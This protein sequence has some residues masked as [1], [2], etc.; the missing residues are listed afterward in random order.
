MNL[1]HLFNYTV[2]MRDT[3]ATGIVFHPRY[4]EIL[5]S[6]RESLASQIGLDQ[7]N[8]LKKYGC[9]LVA[10]A[11]DVKFYQPCYLGE[12]IH[13]KTKFDRSHIAKIYL[14]QEIEKDNLEKDQV[15]NANLIFAFI[16][17]ASMQPKP[18]PSELL[19]QLNQHLA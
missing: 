1:M 9:V 7:N 12:K 16:D 10:H 11:I 2:S 15:L 6:A 5:T 13:V 18:I 14:N 4:L 19:E 8:I 3:D 17:K